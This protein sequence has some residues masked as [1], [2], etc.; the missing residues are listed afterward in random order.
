VRR[1]PFRTCSTVGCFSNVGF[2]ADEIVSFR[3]GAKA[4]L[5]VRPARAPDETVDL[6][7]SLAGFTAGYEA[8]AAAN[9]A[10]LEAEQQQQQQ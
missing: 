1:Y 8:V 5:T 3:R 2:T 7:I 6:T 4:T 10:A 9:A